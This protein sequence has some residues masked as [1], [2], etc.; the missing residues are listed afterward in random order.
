MAEK[1]IIEVYREKKADEITRLIADPDSKLETGS[2]AAASMAFA[3]AFICRAVA[4]C[5]KAGKSGEDIDYVERNAE[6]LRTYMVHLIDEDVKSRGPLRQAVKKGV[7]FEIDAAR[8]PAVSVCSEIVNMVGNGF[9][10]AL[11]LA[12]ACSDD[13]KP[14]LEQYAYTAMGAARTAVS[15]IIAMSSKSSDETFRYVCRRENELMMQQHEEKF[16][17][18]MQKLA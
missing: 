7:A 18:L 5:K 8:E 3:M 12:E 17:A 2:A 1:F 14:Y 6:N 16:N 11:K 9:E 4:L 13:A 15:Y 10:L